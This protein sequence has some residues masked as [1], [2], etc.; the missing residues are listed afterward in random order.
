MKI[1]F[2]ADKFLARTGMSIVTRYLLDGLGD[3]YTPYWF[4]RFGLEGG[5]GVSEQKE[6]FRKSDMERY[7]QFIHIPCDGGV[8]QEA[9]IRKALRMYQIDVAVGYDDWFSSLGL[10]NAFTK[11]K[12]PNI[13]YTPI[14]SLPV[15]VE[16][17]KILSKFD[18]IATP[19][20]GAT[21]YLKRFGIESVHI[22]HGVDCDIFRPKIG[23]YRSQKFT[24]LWM[25]RDEERK[26]LGRFILAL[27]KVKRGHDCLGYVYGDLTPQT[28]NYLNRKLPE[29]YDH[30][31]RASDCPH[32]HIVDEY[33]RCDVYVNTSQAG[34]FELG[35]IEASACEKPVIATGWR[36]MSEVLK[37]EMGWTIPVQKTYKTSRGQIWGKCNIE[38]LASR[39]AECV[40]ERK[41]TAE[42]GREARVYVSENY[43]WGQGIRA[44]RS[45]IEKVM[46]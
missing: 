16:G 37:P 13:F 43:K 35:L 31:G 27:Q 2:F 20:Q 42:K 23:V 46:K 34:G 4:G 40:V 21:G 22:P 17:R 10:L 32:H 9:T 3:D 41:E 6:M 11:L 39:M 44:L 5:G 15:G 30:Y 36:F 38:S 28:E 12:V 25:G 19:S 29:E 1:G 8:W 26:A 24:F 45:A 7:W 14:D 18:L 33:N